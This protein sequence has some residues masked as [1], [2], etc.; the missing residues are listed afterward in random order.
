MFDIGLS[1]ISIILLVALFAIG[2]E[3]M[4]EVA[5][6]LIKLKRALMR[7]KTHVHTLWDEID[8]TLPEE[9]TK[10]APPKKHE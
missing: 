3:R 6:L 7:I 5:K 4:P 9:T 10:K 2:P 8:T 1:E